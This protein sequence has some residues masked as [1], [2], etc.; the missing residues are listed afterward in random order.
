[1]QNKKHYHK[2]MEMLEHGS[3]TRRLLSN[4]DTCKTQPYQT[5]V[6]TLPTLF[7]MCCF[8]YCLFS[9]LNAGFLPPPPSLGGGRW[10]VGVVVSISVHRDSFCHIILGLHFLVQPLQW[11]AV[12]AEIKVPSDEN[13]ELKGSTIKAWS[14]S[15]YCHACYAYCKEFL[16]C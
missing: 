11:G 9:L 12:D 8:L 1:M 15:V 3:T 6:S 13:T 16:P 14:R 4:C 2:Q 5:F 10:R 7:C